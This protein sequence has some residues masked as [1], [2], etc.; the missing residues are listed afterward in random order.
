MAFSISR[1][2]CFMAAVVLSTLLCMIILWRRSS[3]ESISRFSRT[4]FRLTPSRAPM[5][6]TSSKA[7]MISKAEWRIPVSVRLEE[8]SGM[9]LA[10]IRSVSRS[11][12]MLLPLLVTRTTNIDSSGYSEEGGKERSDTKVEGRS[13]WLRV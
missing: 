11:S 12:R 3:W 5:L 7:K 9:S 2:F 13:N 8:Y 6:I 1:A 10:R 4:W